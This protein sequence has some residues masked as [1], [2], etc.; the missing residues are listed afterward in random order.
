MSRIVVIGSSNTDM[1]IRVPV[2]PRPGETVLGGTF[3]V[4]GGGKGANQALA[5]ARAGGAVVFLGRIGDDDF[6]RRALADLSAAAIDTTPCIVD[7]E[8]PSGVAQILVDERGENCIAVAPGANARLAPEDLDTVAASFRAGNV[9]L[10]Q[11]ETPLATVQAALT[12][13]RAAGCHTVLNPA[14]AQP[15]PVELFALVDLL[16]P[17]ESEAELLTGIAVSDD[18]SAAAAA[19]VLHRRGLA[20]VLITRGTHGV[21]LSVAGIAGVQQAFPAFAVNA[22]D[23]TA[24]G[25]VFNGCLAA[26]LAEG[27]P[28]GEAIPF[29]QAGAA[30]SV[31]RPGAQGSVPERAAIE[32]FLRAT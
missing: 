25:D 3:S 16:T 26:A 10:L 24:A 20:A 14:P 23:S 32:A 27:S 17:N 4:N 19:D 13:A 9:V 8:S 7:P 29:A 18:G 11:L 22:V 1:V 30:L 2:L 28:L 12:R 31:Q 6:G 5:A 15:L 21:F